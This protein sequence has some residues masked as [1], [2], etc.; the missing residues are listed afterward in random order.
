MSLPTDILV[1]MLTLFFVLFIIYSYIQNRIKLSE[2]LYTQ[3]IMM[4]S[5]MTAFGLERLSHQQEDIFNISSRVQGQEQWPTHE[6]HLSIDHINIMNELNKPPSYQDDAPPS[7][8][9]AM[10]LAAAKQQGES[11]SVAV[12]VVAPKP[13]TTN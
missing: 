13:S 5:Y 3:G 11:S 2:E 12:I 6:A 1:L 4:D 8:E 10:R 9:E 7:Y